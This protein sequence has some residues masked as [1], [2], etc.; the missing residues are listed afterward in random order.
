MDGVWITTYACF[1][2]LALLIRQKLSEI[3]LTKAMVAGKNEKA[4][5]IFNYLTGV[6]FRQRVEGIVEVFS[7]MKMEL[8][9]E[10]RATQRVWAKKDKQLQTVLYNT[11]NLYGDLQGLI[12]SSMQAIPALET[13]DAEEEETIGVE[14]ENGG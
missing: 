10:K 5:I 2:S 7:D 14:L 12:G 3:A 9:K 13:G 4:D 11:A 8:E 1:Y 6:G